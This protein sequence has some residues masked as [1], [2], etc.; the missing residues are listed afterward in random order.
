MAGVFVS[1]LII[2]IALYCIIYF[3]PVEEPDYIAIDING[4]TLSKL[5]LSMS[6]P[7]AIKAIG[8]EPSQIILSSNRSQLPGYYWMDKEGDTI[9]ISAPE[10][11]IKAFSGSG[12]GML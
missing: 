8:T 12:S 10:G 9:W 6:L 2:R 5:K 11:Y 7:D 3:W 4:T 1:A